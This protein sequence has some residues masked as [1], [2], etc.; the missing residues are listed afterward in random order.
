MSPSLFLPSTPVKGTP[1][2]P[3][4]VYVRPT[5]RGFDV[6]AGNGFGQ[7]FVQDALLSQGRGF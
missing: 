3:P 4:Y 1:P 6:P 5:G 7:I 2:V